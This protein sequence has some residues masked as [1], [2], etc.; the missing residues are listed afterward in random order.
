MD[1][2]KNMTYLATFLSCWLCV[3]VFP[4]KQ[5]YVHQEVFKVASLMAEG[6]IFRL[7]VPVLANIY[8]GLCHIHN[9]S[10]SASYSNACFPLHYVHGWVALYFN[11]H[12]RVPTDVR[13]PLMVGFSGE[14]AA[15][16]YTNFE[17]HVHI[18]KGKYVSWH[19]CLQKQNKDDFLKIRWKVDLLA[20]FILREYS[21]LLPILTVWVYHGH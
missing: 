10:L 16:Y 20:F 19:A 5:T 12:Y 17:A 4:D 2:F 1:E 13:G 14:G 3:F 9:V 11:T 18:Q 8:S 7:V 15:K 6:Y 21:T